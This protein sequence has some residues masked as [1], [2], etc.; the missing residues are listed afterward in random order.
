MV[1]STEETDELALFSNIGNN[2]DL[3]APGVGIVTTSIDGDYTWID[4]TSLSAPIVAGL[5]K[6]SAG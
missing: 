2:I 1:N 4:G 6:D 3:T 5:W